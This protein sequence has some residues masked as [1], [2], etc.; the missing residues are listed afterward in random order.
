MI[1]MEKQNEGISLSTEFQK[2][3]FQDIQVYI[4]L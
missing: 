3:A 2:L 4:S 1:F